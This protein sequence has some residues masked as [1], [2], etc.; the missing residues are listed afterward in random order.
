MSIVTLGFHIVVIVV[1]QSATAADP[2]LQQLRL[3]GNVSCDCCNSI[4][5]DQQLL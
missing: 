2:V 3:N 4:G 5:N 1:I